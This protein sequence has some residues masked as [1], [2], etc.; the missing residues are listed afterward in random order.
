MRKTI[1]L[2]IAIILFIASGAIYWFYFN[3]YGEGYHEGILYSLQR[4]GD[5]FKTYEGVILQPGFSLSKQESLN[6]N[7]FYF[8]VDDNTVADSLTKEIGKLVKVHFVIYRN[9]L[10]WRGE[11]YNDKNKVEGQNIVD[12]IISVFV[13]V[14]SY[15]KY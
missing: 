7:K 1:Y 15:Q 5:I 8:S 10:P 14:T 6:T 2:T 3:R 12:S 9:P 4:E 13:P 11:N